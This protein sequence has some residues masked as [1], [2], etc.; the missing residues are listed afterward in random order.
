MNT[1]KHLLIALAIFSFILSHPDRLVAQTSPK[2]GTIF[3]ESGILTVSDPSTIQST[4]YK[5]RGSRVVFDQRAN[6]WK[7]I[8]AYFFSVVWNDCLQTEAIVNPDFHH[9]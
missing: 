8:N 7:T 4:T 5:E 2:G 1:M 3:I 6:N 9:G